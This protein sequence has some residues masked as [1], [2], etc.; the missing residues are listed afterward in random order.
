[1][2]KYIGGTS[3]S[4]G[5]LQC[6]TTFWIQNH[7]VVDY[8]FQGNYCIP[9]LEEKPGYVTQSVTSIVL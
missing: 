9:P 7:I 4:V 3:P 2:K 5:Q 1:M 6:E 8:S